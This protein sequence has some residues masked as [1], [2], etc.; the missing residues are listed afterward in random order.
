MAHS[1]GSGSANIIALI[2]RGRLGSMS[3]WDEGAS[4]GSETESWRGSVGGELS[5][6]EWSEF[7]VGSEFRAGTAGNRCSWIRGR[8]LV[9]KTHRSRGP[10]LFRF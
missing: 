2:G 4:A 7:R 6:L 10:R 9:S 8:G 1:F 5:E 3:E